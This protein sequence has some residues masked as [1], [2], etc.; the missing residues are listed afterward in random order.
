MK[1]RSQTCTGLTLIELLVV[2]GIIGILASMTA[3]G[4]SGPR[5]RAKILQARI[6]MDN[7]RTAILDYQSEYSRLPASAAAE[8]GNGDMIYGTYG[9]AGFG[10]TP[11]I[12]GSG[13]EASNQ[14]LTL[15]LT[16]SMLN[17]FPQATN[18]VNEGHVR[19][20]R[21]RTFLK[22]NRVVSIQPGL[23]WDAVYRDPW[24][25]PYIVTLDRNNDGFVQPALY[26]RDSVSQSASGGG[27]VGLARQSQPGT[28][29]FALR[30]PVAIWS[31]GPDRSYSPL[32]KADGEIKIGGRMIRNS[33]NLV[34]WA[35]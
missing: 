28:D 34:S 13:H 9:V 20:S 33:D 32:A 25:M 19:N 22:A 21:K 18:T 16:S 11:L 27:L 5:K 14:E 35:K 12:N 23:G 30:Q 26:R 8:G 2:I 15:I 17:Q 24:G 6:D 31:L 3:V 7:L 4:L 29:N 10:G 1:I